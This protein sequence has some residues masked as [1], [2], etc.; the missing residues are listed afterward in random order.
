MRTY[1]GFSVEYEGFEKF[2]LFNVAPFGLATSGH[3]FTKVLRVLITH[4]R[5]QGHKVIMFLDD[6]IGGHLNYDMALNLSRY[7]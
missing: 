2:Y 1:L 3:I 6:G 5:G 7:L 4:W